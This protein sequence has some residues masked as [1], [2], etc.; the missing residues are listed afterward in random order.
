MRPGRRRGS[1]VLRKR[2]GL[3]L[4]MLGSPRREWGWRMCTLLGISV[5]KSFR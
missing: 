1:E 4:E 5:S 2:M 3:L